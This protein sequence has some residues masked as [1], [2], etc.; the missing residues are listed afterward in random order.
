MAGEKVKTQKSVVKD[1][2]IKVMVQFWKVADAIAR[3]VFQDIMDPKVFL[4][5][6]EFDDMIPWKPSLFFVEVRNKLLFILSSWL[7]AG[8]QKLRRFRKLKL[9]LHSHVLDQLKKILVTRGPLRDKLQRKYVGNM[10]CDLA[11]G[12]YFIQLLWNDDDRC[13]E[14]LEVVFNTMT[15]GF[16][17]LCADH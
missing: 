17:E 11:F 2:E 15:N 8:I 12:E 4:S 3:C 16:A 5:S 7:A 13:N 9:V 10:P 1:W 6:Q 14:V